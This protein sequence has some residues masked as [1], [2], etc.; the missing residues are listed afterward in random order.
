MKKVVAILIALMLPIFALI[1][2]GNVENPILFVTPD[3]APALSVAN[4]LQNE[5][6]INGKTE[7]KVV[8]S[9]NVGNYFVTRRADI[10]VLPLNL[11]TKMIDYQIVF[12]NTFGNL[13]IL[14]TEEV[15]ISRIKGNTLYTINLNNVPGLTVRL[16][17]TKCG[18]DYTMNES[19]GN[20]NNVVLKGVNASDLA[21]LFA[22]GKIN[23]AVVA[24]PMCSKLM[25]INS[26]LK[27]IADIQ[28]MY[29][30][31]PQSVLVVKKN[32]FTNAQVEN[33][34]KI[35][36]QQILPNEAF[37]AIN[38]HLEI[39]IVSAFSKDIMSTELINRCN[40]GVMRACEN[41]DFIN[42]YIEKIINLQPN[43]AQKLTDDRF[44]V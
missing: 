10:G 15:D 2:C 39:G 21:G 19:A 24:E 41:K 28:N 29:G 37:D 32:K 17:L 20:S 25:K 18:I 31:Y 27:I 5:Y 23:Y 43:S 4:L 13:Y 38:A 22:T 42:E 7:Y 40:I 3:G 8:Q 34:I 44:F 26:N 36:S 33:I 16:A 1:G 9:A 11:A 6:E 14:A 35:I 30:E 12:V